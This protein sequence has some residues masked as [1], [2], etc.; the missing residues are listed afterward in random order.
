MLNSNRDGEKIIL[1]DGDVELVGYEFQFLS[2]RE[3]GV[4]NS[5]MTGKDD[6][7]DMQR[8]GRRGNIGKG[9]G[10]ETRLF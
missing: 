1:F 9:E 5:L 6:V 3:W 8:I 10:L 7:K 4:S 2:F